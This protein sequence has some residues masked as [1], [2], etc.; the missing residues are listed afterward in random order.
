MLEAPCRTKK[1]GTP[2]S[3]GVSILKEH[4]KVRLQRLE[5]RMLQRG[6][7]QRGVERPWVGPSTYGRWGRNVIKFVHIRL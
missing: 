6:P 3:K 1:L 7:S 4:H 5:G 2:Y